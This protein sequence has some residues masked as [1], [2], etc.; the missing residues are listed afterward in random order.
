V[1]HCAGQDIE[2]RLPGE[3]W[4]DKNMN[5]QCSPAEFLLWVSASKY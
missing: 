1:Q 5:G 3:C 4:S 2:Y